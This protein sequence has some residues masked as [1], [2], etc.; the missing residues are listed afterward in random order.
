MKFY[1]IDAYVKSV[2]YSPDICQHTFKSSCQFEKRYLSFQWIF[3]LP[4]NPLTREDVGWNHSI[5]NKSDSFWWSIWQ[6]GLLF[7]GALKGRW[8]CLEESESSKV[9]GFD[10][11]AQW[12]LRWRRQRCAGGAPCGGTVILAKNPTTDH[13]IKTLEIWTKICSMRGDFL[14]S[15]HKR[16]KPQA[17]TPQTPVRNRQ[18]RKVANAKGLSRNSNLT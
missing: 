10:W 8:F 14:G 2:S 17:P 4:P 11:R 6:Y 1:F 18:T 15:C 12:H 3:S 13:R 9:I 5:S 7:P 16:H